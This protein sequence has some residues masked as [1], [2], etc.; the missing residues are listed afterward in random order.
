MVSKA[1]CSYGRIVVTAIVVALSLAGCRALPP[2]PAVFNDEQIAALQELGFEEGAA[3]WELNLG[4]RILFATGAHRLTARDRI[5]IRKVAETLR[6][7]GIDSM[8]IEGHADSIGEESFNRALSLR[9][10]ESVA[11]EMA[12]NGVT[13]E[14]I[15]IRGMGTLQPVADNRTRAGRMQNRRATI[16]VPAH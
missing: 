13:Y 6:A 15:Q 2:K 3:G 14:N 8:R 1:F 9:R 5:E 10:A 12:A 7:V 4:S 16:I 11:R